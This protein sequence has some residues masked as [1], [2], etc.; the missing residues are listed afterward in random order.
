VKR[1]PALVP[2][3][4]D[5]HHG[6]VQARRLRRAASGDAQ[7]LSAA[8][9]AFLDFFGRE[10]AAHF[11]EE[12]ELLFPLL[13]AV[14]APAPPEL[15]EALV[16][17]ARLRALA[18]RLRGELERGA[19][20]A[21]TAQELGELLEEHIRL[22][23]RRLFPLLEE[24][25]SDEE[26]RALELPPRRPEPVGEGPV[27]RLAAGEGPGPVWG[28][29]SEDLNATLLAWPPGAGTPAQVNEERDVLLVVLAGTGTLELDGEPH[30]LAHAHAAVVPKGRRFRIA[31]GP[32]G[33]RYLSVHLRRPYLQVAH[34]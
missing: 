9:A 3:S 16:Q 25:V 11:R 19:V 8:A 26:L 17:H 28:T 14:S 15:A 13:A 32:T 12:E 20:E 29:A 31:A 30:P 2:F 18:D 27:V 21:A 22:E 23:E 10:A 1:H 24:A 4:H 33:L 34:A 5:H 7:E 6:L